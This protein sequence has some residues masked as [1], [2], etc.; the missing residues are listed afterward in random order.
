MALRSQLLTVE[1]PNAAGKVVPY[2]TYDGYLEE[3]A[4][5]TIRTERRSF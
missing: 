2:F 3:P 4:R 5:N 1:L